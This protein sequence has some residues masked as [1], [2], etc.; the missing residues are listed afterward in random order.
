MTKVSTPPGEFSR[1][2]FFLFILMAPAGLAIIIAIILVTQYRQFKASVSP[3]PEVSEFMWDASSQSRLDSVVINLREFS[4]ND[5]AKKS[6][7]LWLNAEDLN[8]L[9][10]S[11]PVIASQGIHFHADIKD[12]QITLR[13]TQA[14]QAMQGKFAG[15]FKKIAKSGYLNARL[16]GEPEWKDGRLEFS[17]D[18]GF[19]NGQKVVAV[20][21][22]KRG[23]MSPRDFLTDTVAYAEF[24]AALGDVKATDGKILLIRKR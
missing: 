9:M 5:S 15:I 13:S 24:I 19:L 2:S 23:G 3:I 10:A 20:A 14:V 18:S 7:S 6:D 11:S 8:L 21:L 12:D 4:A 16:E 1:R 17:P 22:Q